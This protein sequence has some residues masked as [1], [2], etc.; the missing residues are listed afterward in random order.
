VAAEGAGRVVLMPAQSGPAVLAHLGDLVAVADVH[1][2]QV[3][4]P[5]HSQ[6]AGW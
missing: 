4:D 3:G 6:T 1:G 5:G 2:N